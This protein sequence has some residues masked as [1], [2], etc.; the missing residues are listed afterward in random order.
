MSSVAD[1]LAQVTGFMAGSKSADELPWHPENTKLPSR[2]N[3]PSIPGA[4]EGAAW[5]WGKDDYV[6]QPLFLL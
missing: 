4:P 2:K 1:K 3:L 5:V 6:G